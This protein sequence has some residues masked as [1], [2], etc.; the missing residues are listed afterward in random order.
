V[1]WLIDNTDVKQ[2]DLGKVSSAFAARFTPRVEC[3]QTGSILRLL[4][5]SKGSAQALSITASSVE[6][7]TQLAEEI[8]RQWAFLQAAND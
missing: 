3:S 6:I 8:P 1:N 4:L 7:A 2:V 5:V